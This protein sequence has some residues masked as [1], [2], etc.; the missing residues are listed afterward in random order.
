MRAS[1]QDK[2]SSK[3]TVIMMT[4]CEISNLYKITGSVADSATQEAMP[5]KTQQKLKPP[6]P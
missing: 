5:E 2:G 4:G 1:I 3:R 6:E